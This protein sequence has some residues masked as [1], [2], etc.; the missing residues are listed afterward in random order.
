MRIIILS[1]MCCLFWSGFAFAGP[2]VEMKTNLGSIQIT[3]DAEKAPVTVKNFLEYVDQKFYDGTIF[4]RVIKGFMIQAGGFDSD[5]KRKPTK[6][7][8]RNEAGNGLKNLKGTIAMARTG[9]VDSAT[10]QFFINLV[11]NDF[12]NHRGNSARTF[13][14][15]VFGRVTGGIDVVEKIGDV[16]TIAKSPVFKDFPEPVVVIESVRRLD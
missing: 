16:K 2:T 6:A 13:G 1:L 3:L 4:H 15:A 14:Y 9:V 7:P 11:D 5:E 12:L 8:I 10:S